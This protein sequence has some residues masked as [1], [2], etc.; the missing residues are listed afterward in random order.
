[1]TSA[2]RVLVVGTGGL[3]C[4]LGA[5]LARSGAAVTLAGTWPEA[6]AAIAER[7]VVVHEGEAEWSVP[8]SAVP[9]DARLEPF[10]LA[11]VLV[12]SHRTVA[13][14]AALASALAA[15]GLALTLQNG[16]GHR[17]TLAAA[18]G[19]S[20]AG[21]GVALLGATVLGPG[22][23]R[24]H[25]GHVVLGTDGPSAER[26]RQ[27]EQLL[28]GAGIP[29]ETTAEID[30]AVWTK[31]AANCAINALTALYRVPNGALLERGEWRAELEAIAREVAKVAA[32]CGIV[33]DDAAG[34]ALVVARAT[35]ENRSSMLQDVE[36]G[37][38]TEID[39]LN[40]AVVR[41]GSRRGIPTPLNGRLHAAIRQLEGRPLP[42]VAETV[43]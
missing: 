5:R 31:L 30:T 13:A 14:A 40:G 2:P 9:L 24:F 39:A 20:R 33:L 17:E 10:P 18:L 38:P 21:A 6:L 42:S 4:A 23:V 22:I 3:A 15:D 32:A 29:A 28:T 7:G 26:V 12:K 25:P 37:A 8:V 34:T 19:P 41:E 43:P 1:V 35:A 16:L 27:L 11:L 36:R